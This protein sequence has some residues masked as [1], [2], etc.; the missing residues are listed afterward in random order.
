MRRSKMRF[1]SPSVY[2]SLSGVGV[3][4]A[5]GVAD[6]GSSVTAE[7][8]PLSI[9]VAVGVG[10]VGEGSAV[11][12]GVANGISV[13]VAVMMGAIVAVAG[14]TT[15]S[16]VAVIVGSGV[17]VGATVAVGLGVSAGDWNRPELATRSARHKTTTSRTEPSNQGPSRRIALASRRTTPAVLRD[18]ISCL[19]GTF[20]VL[21]K[22]ELFWLQPAHSTSRTTAT[23]HVQ[24]CQESSGSGAHYSRCSR[25]LPI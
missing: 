9:A 17:A 3:V 14:G 10:T 7:G 25:L 16:G 15:V 12:V 20:P 4:D 24:L 18:F 19:I 6:G 8:V 5:A 21:G 11:D 22:S 2:R 23:H 1:D 13:A